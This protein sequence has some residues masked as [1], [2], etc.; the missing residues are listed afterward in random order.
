MILLIKK[1][2]VIETTEDFKMFL[3]E[4]KNG[5]LASILFIAS[6][7]ETAAATAFVHR[8]VSNVF[9]SLGVLFPAACGDKK[10]VL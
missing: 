7:T 2:H 6:V 3:L 8:D 10:T 1:N 9:Q 5:I 4:I